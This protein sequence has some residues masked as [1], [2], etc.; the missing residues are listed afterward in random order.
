MFPRL[1]LLA[2]RGVTS[3]FLQAMYRSTDRIPFGIR[4]IGREVFHVLRAKFP[5]EPQ[6]DALRVVAHLIYYRF[7]QPAAV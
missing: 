3:D 4:Y 6:K 7:I 2:I 5:N 1:D